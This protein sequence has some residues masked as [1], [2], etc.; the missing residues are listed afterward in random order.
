MGKRVAQMISREACRRAQRNIRTSR[1]DAPYRAK[2]L[3]KELTLR[4]RKYEKDVRI[5]ISCHESF[6]LKFVCVRTVYSLRSSSQGCSLLGEICLQIGDLQFRRD[7]VEVDRM[8]K[9]EDEREAK[10]QSRKLDFLLTQTEIFAHFMSHRLGVGSVS[11]GAPATS[12]SVATVA[13][14]LTSP[15]SAL[16]SLATSSASSS[17]VKTAGVWASSKSDVEQLASEAQRATSDYIQTQLSNAAKFDAEHALLQRTATNMVDSS[18]VANSS[19]VVTSASVERTYAQ[20]KIF[21]GSL[22]A[23]Q[24]KGLNWLVNLYDQ[25]INGILGT[26]VTQ[27]F[28]FSQLIISIICSPYLPVSMWFSSTADEMGVS[29]HVSNDSFFRDCFSF[30]VE[31]L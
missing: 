28:F 13:R 5:S 25:G 24:L 20:P 2:K 21:R 16:L 18:S 8:K 1:A 22:K 17:L 15:P 4:W 23:Y 27:V 19:S 6:L 11:T 31:K 14:Q 29:V 10:R 30:L 26:C 12:T 7:K 9:E 3:G